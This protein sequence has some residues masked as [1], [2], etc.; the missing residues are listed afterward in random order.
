MILAGHNR[1][2][3]LLGVAPLV[4]NN[5]MASR[6]QDWVNYNLAHGTFTHCVFV[7]GWEQIQS[8]MHHEG[9]NGAAWNPHSKATPAQMQEFW[10]AENSTDHWLQVVSTNAT[11]IG[12]AYGTGPNPKDPQSDRDVMYCRYSPAG[13]NVPEMIY[14]DWTC[15]L[16]KS[17]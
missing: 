1:E 12:C 16:P 11:S 15:R 10:F 14:K 3:A 9:E 8:C 13:I 17:P 4:W 2:R 6:S 5:E 7:K